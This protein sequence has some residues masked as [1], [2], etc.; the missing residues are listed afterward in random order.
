MGL[1]KYCESANKKRWMSLQIC[2]RCFA[3]AK[4]LVSLGKKQRGK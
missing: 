1:E 3:F 4:P 2:P